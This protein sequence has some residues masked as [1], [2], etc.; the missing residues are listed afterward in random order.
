MISKLEDAI[1]YCQS[2]E[3]E[4]A[5][6]KLN[7][8][9]KQV[10]A[11]RGKPLTDE[12]ADNMIMLAEIM[13]TAI[14]EGTAGCGEMMLESRSNYNLDPLKIYP[15]PVQSFINISGGQSENKSLVLIYDITGRLVLK[16]SHRPSLD[17]SELE[18]GLYFLK[19]GDQ[20]QSFIKI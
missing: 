13:I 15:N 5:I 19:L 11:K 17:V 20:T 4:L 18:S 1:M 8:F 2:G 6:E 9:I 10:N 3:T 14:E 12:E 16:A 7:A